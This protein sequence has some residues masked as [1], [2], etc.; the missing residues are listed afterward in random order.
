MVRRRTVL[1][2]LLALL[3]W[4][5]QAQ[6]FGSCRDAGYLEEFGFDYS[7]QSCRTVVTTEIRWRGGRA[8]MRVIV[9]DVATP[10][11][12]ERE[13]EFIRNVESLAARMGRAMDDMSGLRL[14]PVTILLSDAYFRNFHALTREPE[15]E[16]KVTFLKQKVDEGVEEEEFLFTLSHEIFHCI[17][18]ST[19]PRQYQADGRGEI[20]DG[21][22]RP[23]DWWI[24]GSAEYFALLANPGSARSDQF[25]NRFDANI[26]ATALPDMD[27]PAV[28]L[29]LWLHQ[30][31]DAR[32]VKHFID[33]MALDGGTDPQRE[34]LRT[35]IPM[36]DWLDF[37]QTYLD[38]RL[39]QPGGRTPTW[40]INGGERVV[41]DQPRR[42]VSYTSE[43]TLPRETFVFKKGRTYKLAVGDVNGEPRSRFN[44]A[45][46]EW[47]D[48]PGLVRACDDDVS[49]VVLTTALRGENASLAFTVEQSERL[50]ERACCL[51]GDWAPTPESRQAELLLLQNHGGPAL[52]A[53]G[54]SLNCADNGGDWRLRF[55]ADATG[56]VDWQGFSYRCE[57]SGPTGGWAH[58]Q[59]R[60]GSTDFTWTVLDREVGSARYTDN[61]LA[62]HHVMELGPIRQ[63]R[64]LADAGPS[65][66]SNNFAFQCT[67]TTLSVQG[68]YGLNAGQGTY[69]RVDAPAAEPRP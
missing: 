50:D 27:Y 35:L 64:V 24:E 18:G 10:S 23:A 69:T 25:F 43:F 58:M 22:V 68:I 28:V 32:G 57:T 26:D 14:K 33:G 6:A 19:W 29:F 53:H 52:A 16:C 5:L 46:G 12:N 45:P 36:D 8:P 49:H 47:I 9:P 39:R 65:T 51:V 20:P 37:G 15:A 48:P 56:Q 44:Q 7:P 41:F 38:G 1:L 60:Q 4:P 13:A 31:G 21:G 67:N 3:A 40:I 30:V 59:T 42:H 2:F 54:A 11:L 63:S 66:E 55:T 62:W 17:Q 34:A 61:S